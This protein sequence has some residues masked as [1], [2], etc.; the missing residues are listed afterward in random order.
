MWGIQLNKKSLK[1][2]VGVLIKNKFEIKN[3]YDN[4][5]VIITIRLLN[6][7][8]LTSSPPPQ[9][10]FYQHPEMP[11]GKKNVWLIDYINCLDKKQAIFH[12]TLN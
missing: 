2:I 7:G 9:P 11:Y 5:E 6:L 3:S 12:E 8:L 4:F 1:E 10:W